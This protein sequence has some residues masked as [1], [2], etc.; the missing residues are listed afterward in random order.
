[1]GTFDRQIALFGEEGQA[2]IRK[3][4]VA[5]VGVGGIGTHLVQQ[6]SLLGVRDIALIDHEELDETNLNRYIG[7]RE[8]DPIP[9][10]LKVNIGER[11]VRAVDAQANVVTVPHR[12]QS[13]DGFAA[14]IRA[15]VVFGCLDTEG[16]RFIL[17]ELCVAYDLKL[18]DCATEVLPEE[19]LIYG[20]HVHILWD[21]PG[22]L[23]CL[24]LLDMNAVREDLETSD[25]RTN[26]ESVYGVDREL[27]RQSGPSVVSL[28][29]VVASIGVSEFMVAITGLR[30]PKQCTT[31]R[32]DLGRITTAFTPPPG[33]CYTCSL[34]GARDSAKVERF[35]EQPNEPLT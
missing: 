30:S 1:M 21:R 19:P 27:L 3:A 22:C 13:I 23:Y 14:I 18:I 15:D 17:N 4:K 9:G 8:G 31:Y 34:L 20:G 6:L 25:Q 11:L 12:F 5:V 26:R 7:V 24:G 32:A 29:G 33:D 16:A 10:T 2:A 35:I 28:N